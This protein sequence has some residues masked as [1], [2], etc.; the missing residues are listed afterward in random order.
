MHHLT[1]KL[2][3]TRLENRLKESCSR[4]PCDPSADAHVLTLVNTYR[5][6]VVWRPDDGGPAEA[7]AIPSGAERM[8]MVTRLNHLDDALLPASTTPND[9]ARVAAAV[10]SML[11]GGYASLQ[12]VDRRA[13]IAGYTEALQDLPAWAVELGCDA[14][15]KGKVAD[16]DPKWPPTHGHL[17]QIAEKQ[18]APIKAE[19]AQIAGVLALQL[20]PQPDEAER[21]RMA[22][23]AKTW[24][25]RSDPTA[26]KLIEGS[27]ESEAVR[28]AKERTRQSMI[29]GDREA[30]RREWEAAGLEPRGYSLS[31]AKQLGKL[32]LAPPTKDSAAA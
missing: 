8:A 22:E 32:D 12:N 19:Q 2:P 27:E 7:A 21:A 18:L 17:H 9:V 20:P 11:G 13:T 25:D 3:M 15:R 10:S 30:I 6:L 14:V 31:L 16:L 4:L 5:A 26:Q 23:A 28:E 1:A 29:S 24:L